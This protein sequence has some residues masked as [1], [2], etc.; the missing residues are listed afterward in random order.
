[1]AKVK[2]AK[3]RKK[4]AHT[5]E[6]SDTWAAAWLAQVQLTTE[7]TDVVQELRSRLD[8]MREN[9]ANDLEH[10]GRMNDRC[11]VVQRER[12]AAID[13]AKL[14]TAAA[15]VLEARY[16]KLDE[17][18]R[19]V[20]EAAGEGFDTRPLEQRRL[21]MAEAAQALTYFYETLP[22]PLND[23]VVTLLERQAADAARDDA[24]D[25]S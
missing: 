20:V 13:H 11:E 18:V 3:A 25:D 16:C 9:H 21:D 10:L 12:D 2:R 1:M 4:A 17:V 6:I 23:D 19:T 24:A 14:L 7:L 15:A 5:V 22:K 8:C